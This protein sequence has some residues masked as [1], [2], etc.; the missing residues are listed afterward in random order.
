L[1]NARSSVANGVER[2]R[3]AQCE[4]FKFWFT[5]VFCGAIAVPPISVF[6]VSCFDDP[7]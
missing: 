5:S 3:Y 7:T 6:A 4:F 1:L 2:T